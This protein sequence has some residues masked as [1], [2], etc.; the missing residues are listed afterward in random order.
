[1]RK[2]ARVTDIQMSFDSLYD[3]HISDHLGVHT[4]RFETGFKAVGTTAIPL[5]SEGKKRLTGKDFKDESELTSRLNEIA[6]G[7]P[8]NFIVLV[9]RDVGISAEKVKRQWVELT[10]RWIQK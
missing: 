2:A 1:M 4:L 5:Y 10:A 7:D 6:K 9:G 8:Q 3:G